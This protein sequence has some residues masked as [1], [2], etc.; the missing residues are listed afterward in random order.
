MEELEDWDPF[1]LTLLALLIER[2]PSH[3]SSWIPVDALARLCEEVGRRGPTILSSGWDESAAARGL[4]E[5]RHDSSGSAVRLTPEGRARI[6][7]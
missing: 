7:V 6:G 1:F 4:L 2:Q 3:E 5:T